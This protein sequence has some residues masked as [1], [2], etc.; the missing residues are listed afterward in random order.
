MNNT[1]GRGNVKGQVAIEKIIE[2][3][4]L[5]DAK[6]YAEL[7]KD[8]TLT[9]NVTADNRTPEQ[10]EKDKQAIELLKE[11][12]ECQN[13][14]L[15]YGFMLYN[16]SSIV[17]IYWTQRVGKL[18]QDKRD[19]FGL[20]KYLEWVTEIFTTLNGDHPKFHDPLYYY[21]FD[22]VKKG[23][24]VGFY[25]VMNSFTIQWNRFFLSQLAYYLYQEDQKYQDFGVSIEDALESENGAGNHMEAE[26]SLKNGNTS[27]IEDDVR[28]LAVE[29]FLKAFNKA[30]LNGTVPLKAGTKASGMTYKD[31]MK[32]IVDGTMKSASNV[33]SKFTIGLNVQERIMEK[34]KKYMESYGV[35]LQSLADYITD[36]RIVALDILD[37]RNTSF[38]DYE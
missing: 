14:A 5:S 30:P 3:E 2:T 35:D 13:P 38:H 9:G 29:D 21:K 27:S 10:E 7:M 22:T 34:I 16:E 23:Q 26:I 19:F 17:K 32:A 36:Y 4:Y 28:F 1:Q 6:E 25:D 24:R 31:F 33:R 15:A 8:L 18:R 37:G 20:D 12:A 11:L